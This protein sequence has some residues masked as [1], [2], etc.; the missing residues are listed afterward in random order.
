MDDLYW[1]ES[2]ISCRLGAICRIGRGKLWPFFPHRFPMIEATEGSLGQ[3][4][5]VP[6]RRLQGLCETS[7]VPIRIQVRFLEAG[8][9]DASGA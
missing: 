1:P 2:W 7:T 9:H 4:S 3:V 5:L 8:I 6:I